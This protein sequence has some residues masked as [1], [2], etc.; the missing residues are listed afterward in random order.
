MSQ[1]TQTPN[2]DSIN[3]SRCLNAKLR[4]LHR[5]LN[6]VYQKKIN[7]FGLRGSMLSILFIVGKRKKVNQRLLAEMLILDESTMS[8][9][10]KALEAKGWIARER[11]VEDRRR[12]ELTVT[13]EGY[14]LLE[15]VAPI[16][17]KLHRSV[18]SLLGLHQ[19]TQIDAMTQ[20]IRQNLNS[21]QQ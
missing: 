9:D 13:P 10:I 17:D 14:Q 21:L 8:R 3:P 1:H 20:A 19:I 15:E 2:F 7:P 11:S 5:L 12:Y 4:K 6:S 18:E 16:W